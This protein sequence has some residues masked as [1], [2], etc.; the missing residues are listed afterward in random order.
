VAKKKNTHVGW[1][2]PASVYKEVAR[3]ARAERRTINAQAVLLL[4]EALEA[5]K[6][7]A[8]ALR[9]HVWYARENKGSAR[10]FHG[11]A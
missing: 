4:S 2:I 9:D 10:Q 5:R 7:I 11:D 6:E 8:D 3:M 1:C